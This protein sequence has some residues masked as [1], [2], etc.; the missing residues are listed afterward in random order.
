MGNNFLVYIS[1][2][3]IP[4]IFFYVIGYALLTGSDIFGDFIEGAKEGFEVTKG[5]MP[6]LIGLLVAVGVLRA[7]G[8]F[9]ILGRVAGILGLPSEIFPI[10]IVKMF[11]SSAA[12][13]L[14]LDLFKSTGP[15]SHVSVLASIMMSSSETI[16]YTVSVYFGS[17]GIK[18]TGY[19]IPGA[20][21]ATLAA[22]IASV[23]LVR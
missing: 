20:L 7:S 10:V 12:S 4:I 16:F 18:K 23:W 13:G 15:D 21:F 1:D 14:L 3:I 11:S 5:I 9:E 6:T 2:Y 17:V 19:V 8:S 22:V